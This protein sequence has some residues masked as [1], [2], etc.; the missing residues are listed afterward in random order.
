MYLSVGTEE[1]QWKKHC[2]KNMVSLLN[3]SFTGD[4]ELSK[5]PLGVLADRYISRPEWIWT[6]QHCDVGLVKDVICG[7]EWSQSHSLSWYQLWVR[8]TG[9][10]ETMFCLVRWLESL[11]YR[12]RSFMKVFKWTKLVSD[13]HVWVG[14]KKLNYTSGHMPQNV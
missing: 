2:F 11:L 8:N 7:P 10:E 9:L 14:E 6:M 4:L 5:N 12:S 1:K 13:Q 3:P